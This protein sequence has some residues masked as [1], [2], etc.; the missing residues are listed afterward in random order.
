VAGGIQ[1]CWVVVSHH[2]MQCSFGY[3]QLSLSHTFQSLNILSFYAF[4]NAMKK[5]LC[6]ISFINLL[7]YCTLLRDY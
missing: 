1:V 4:H 2:L 3:Q 5:I 7:K 6:Q